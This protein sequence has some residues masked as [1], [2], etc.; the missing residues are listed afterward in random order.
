MPVTVEKLEY[1]KETQCREFYSEDVFN[2]GLE[3]FHNSKTPNTILILN[4]M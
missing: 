3:H 1:L 4:S 2:G